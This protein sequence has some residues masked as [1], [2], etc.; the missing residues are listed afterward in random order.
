MNWISKLFGRQQD[1]KAA[2]LGPQF[3]TWLEGTVAPSDISR[4]FAQQYRA[5]ELLERAKAC[6]DVQICLNMN[7]EFCANQP[8]RL[9]RSPDASNPHKGVKARAV[10][11]GKR[12]YLRNV[13]STGKSAMY[14]ERAGPNIEEIVEHPILELLR[15]PNF[16]NNWTDFAQNCFYFLEATG[17]MYLQP[18]YD[19]GEYPSA[20]MQIYPQYMQLEPSIDNFVGGYWLWNRDATKVHFKPDEIDHLIYRRSKINQYEGTGWVESVLMETEVLTLA[21]ASQVALWLNNGVPDKILKL[22]EGFSGLSP[23]QLETLEAKFQQ[24]YGGV[25]NRGKFHI[26]A[27]IDEVLDVGS[28]PKELQFLQILQ[29]YRRAIWRAA[30]VPQSIFE[31]NQA[32]LASALA[33]HTQ[34]ARVTIQPRLINFAEQMTNLLMPRFGMKPGE[35]FFAFDNSVPVD[36]QFIQNSAVANATARILTVD[37]VRASLDYPPLP[38]GEGEKL[39][40]PYAVPVAAPIER[41][42]ADGSEAHPQDGRQQSEGNANQ[43]YTGA[44][45]SQPKAEAEKP[46]EEAPAKAAKC[47]DSDIRFSK[48]DIFWK[49]RQLE[50]IDSKSIDTAVNALVSGI[51]SWFSES[52]D[53]Q[54]FNEKAL[55]SKIEKPVEQIFNIGGKKG[56]GKLADAPGGAEAIEALGISWDANNE[57]RSKFLDSYTVRLSER[58]TKEQRNQLKEAIRSS[59]DEGE[60]TREATDRVFEA[61][62]LD[63]K[64]K[65]ERIARTESART[66]SQGEL[67]S[68][69]EAGVEGKQWILAAGSCPI[70]DEIAKKYEKAI[71]LQ[72]NF[73][74]KGHSVD[75]AEGKFTFDYED[76]DSPPAHPQCRCTV[77]PV[78]SMPK[79]KSIDATNTTETQDNVS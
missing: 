52:C 37:E 31:S 42:E 39:S 44:P 79:G 77:V 2:S 67:T 70:C 13:E 78:V 38:N 56:L 54:S 1:T 65:A 3:S 6:S 40:N 50:A 19:G 73:F 64:W 22:S 72:D 74:D 60:S 58:I 68:W 62:N 46:Q 28:T 14:A 10:S 9:Y 8:M 26:T 5:R 55:H 71:S 51:R 21:T 69:K 30:G 48:Q 17:N 34:Y 11:Y 59:I 47:L 43:G 53:K 61:L 33:G 25:K 35:Y 12:A 57:E 45:E 41:Q 75:T 7:A 63:E 29:E 18:I 32:N 24:L 23:Q 4:R 20:L 36:R 27:A 15:K 49:S 16:F 76:I 66:Y